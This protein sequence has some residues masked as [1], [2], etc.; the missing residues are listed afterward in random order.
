MPEDVTV[1]KYREFKS[2]LPD[3]QKEIVE[4]REKVKEFQREAGEDIT[5]T[6]TQ[7]GIPFTDM[8]NLIEA[9]GVQEAIKKTNDIEKGWAGRE[10]LPTKE[11][12]DSMIDGL[13][14]SISKVQPSKEKEPKPITVPETVKVDTDAVQQGTERGTKQMQETIIKRETTKMTSPVVKEA[15]NAVQKSAEEGIFERRQALADVI[16]VRPTIHEIPSITNKAVADETTAGFLSVLGISP[17]LLGA[18]ALRRAPVAVPATVKVDTDAIQQGTE[19]GTKQMQETIIKRETT[20]TTPPSVVKEAANAVQKGTEQGAIKGSQALADVIP[21][22]PTIHGT[23]SMIGE[24]V[25]DK[26]SG[27]LPSIGAEAQALMQAPVV[28]TI[29]LVLDNLIVHIDTINGLEELAT[30]FK[31]NTEGA[32]ASYI[33]AAIGGYTQPTNVV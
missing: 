30:K 16:P 3:L 18:H 19:R 14:D 26:A 32:L 24:T 17:L 11:D 2:K 28:S 1:T 8:M 25:V 7:T 33:S 20:K 29:N 22:Q 13:R 9:F 23:P 4:K 31:T 5:V 21:V 6:M 12:I 27:I 15:A 10:K